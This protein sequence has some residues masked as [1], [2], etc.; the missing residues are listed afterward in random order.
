MLDMLRG[1]PIEIVV[2]F[3]ENFVFVLKRELEIK[4]WNANWGKCDRLNIN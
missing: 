3:L 2:Y 1:S 4:M